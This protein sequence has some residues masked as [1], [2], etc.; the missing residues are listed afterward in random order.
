MEAR[1]EAISVDKEVKLSAQNFSR[2]ISDAMRDFSSIFGEDNFAYFTKIGP[3]LRD[4]VVP[5]AETA[6]LLTTREVSFSPSSY[7][8]LD[9][10]EMEP[11]LR[12]RDG[13]IEDVNAVLAALRALRDAALLDDQVAYD[14]AEDDLTRVRR[15]LASYI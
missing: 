15:Q 10:P 2:R 8:Y 6:S 14:Q 4:D 13:Y 3:K 1:T 9:S 7:I 11:A 5:A 12:R